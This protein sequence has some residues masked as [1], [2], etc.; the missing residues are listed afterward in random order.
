MKICYLENI[1]LYIFGNENLFFSK[2]VLS[3]YCCWYFQGFQF[4]VMLVF[5]HLPIEQIFIKLLVNDIFASCKVQIFMLFNKLWKA[6]LLYTDAKEY[7]IFTDVAFRTELELVDKMSAAT[8]LGEGSALRKLEG[9]PQQ[10]QY[11]WSL[12][13]YT[14]KRITRLELW[15]NSTYNSGTPKITKKLN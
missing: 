15:I 11:C 9:S 1:N 4:T 8:I 13:L 5:F 7:K 14:T 12:L 2:W 6:L 10:Q 3:I